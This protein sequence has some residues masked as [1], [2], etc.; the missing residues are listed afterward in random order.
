MDTLKNYF[1]RYESE[2]YFIL[3]AEVHLRKILS[4]AALEYYFF[5]FFYL[6]DIP[7][8]VNH[9]QRN[10]LRFYPQISFTSFPVRIFN[11]ANETV[12]R[13]SYLISFNFTREKRNTFINRIFIDIR[14]RVGSELIFFFRSINRIDTN[15]HTNVVIDTV[16]KGNCNFFRSIIN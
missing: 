14:K 16:K 11:L 3:N 13:N 2:S 1:S 5:F 10:S 7:L 15:Q 4:R 8:W 9:S 12:K 6:V